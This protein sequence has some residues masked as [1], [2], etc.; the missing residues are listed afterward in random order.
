MRIRLTPNAQKNR[1]NG[2]VADKQGSGILRISID[3]IPEQGR[4]YKALIKY[5]SI[6][7]KIT[8]SKIALVWGQKDRTKTLHIDAA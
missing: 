1:N 2:I 8:K 3:A 4:A 7:W 5:V 6:L